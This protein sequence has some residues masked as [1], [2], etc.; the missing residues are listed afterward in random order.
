MK[1]WVFW[2]WFRLQRLNAN[3]WP[4]EKK[5]PVNGVVSRWVCELT[6]QQLTVHWVIVCRFA[7]VCILV[8]QY[9]TDELSIILFVERILKFPR[10]RQSVQECKVFLFLIYW[11]EII[12]TYQLV[13]FYK[14][15]KDTQTSNSH[16]LIISHR[17][18]INKHRNI[19][20]RKTYYSVWLSWIIKS[21]SEQ[22]VEFFLI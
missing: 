5:N 10:I 13:H 6:V 1:F 18:H 15:Q 8:F 3:S 17:L 7:A 20:H 11:V 9:K 2:E 21:L 14:R 4:K 16:K 19:E 12:E 22:S